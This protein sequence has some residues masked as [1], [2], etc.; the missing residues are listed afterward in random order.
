MSFFTQK[1]HPAP[2]KAEVLHEK[3]TKN[4]QKVDQKNEKPPQKT[5]SF[6]RKNENR[7]TYEDF[8]KKKIE[9]KSRTPTSTNF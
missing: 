8:E 6:A 5:R 9:K 3:M 4:W 1:G 2:Q 7:P